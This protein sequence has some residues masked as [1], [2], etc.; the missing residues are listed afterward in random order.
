MGKTS[1][2]DRN[3]HL[4]PPNW[5]E[6]ADAVKDAAGR[7]CLGCGAPHGPPPHVLTVHHLDHVPMNCDDSNLLPCCQRC[8]LRLGP[9]I[10]TKEEAISRLQRRAALDG[11]QREMS[12]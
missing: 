7:R 9:G 5:K 2:F 8:H 12:L 4:Y 3:K 10:Y 6:I 1:W 11:L